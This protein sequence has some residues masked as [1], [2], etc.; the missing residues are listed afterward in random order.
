MQQK[1]YYMYTIL[2]TLN[3]KIYVGQTMHPKQRWS[4]H[5]AYSKRI[6]PVQ[7][8]HRAMAKYGIDNF[9]FEIIA[10]CKNKEYAGEI[11]SQLIIQYDSRNEDKGYNIAPGGIAGWNAGLPTE[12]QPMYGKHHSEES[13]RKISEG[14][15]GKYMPPRTE[16]QKR[17]TSETMTGRVSPMLGKKQ[18]DKFIQTMSKIHK[19]NKYNLG[20][21]FSD[22]TKAKI[23][24]VSIGR[25]FSIETRKKISAANTGNIMSD[26]ARQKMSNA[27]SGENH[28][29]YGKERSQETKEKISQANIGKPHGP[30]SEETKIKIS[31][32]NIGRPVS[33]ETRKKISQANRMLSDEQIIEIQQSALT[34]V[35]LGKIYGVGKSTIW[36]IKNKFKTEI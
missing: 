18:S 16:D 15:I 10:T 11:E 23:S 27:K 8:I 14:N 30:M 31:K 24:A 6:V 3:N 19:N 36:R 21:K 5:K 28:P 22:E 9:I 35:A 12:Q 7:Y 33:Q 32:A 13:R 1:E 4:Q 20:R 29:N 26:E 17:I 2:D 34:L 25:Q